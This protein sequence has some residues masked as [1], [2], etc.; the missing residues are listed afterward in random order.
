VSHAETP[1][2][3]ESAPGVVSVEELDALKAKVQELTAA[4]Q[5]IEGQLEQDKAAAAEAEKKA[6]V[7][8]T[9][10]GGLRIASADKRYEL[11]IGGSI[12]YDVA[13]FRQDD[14]LK[15]AV[16]D[17]Q[18]GTGFRFA[19]LRLQ[20]KLAE[21]VGFRA[22]YDFAGE[23]AADSPK[24]MDVYIDYLGIPWGGG[25]AFDVRAGHFREPF[26][27]EE[28]TGIANRTF[29]ERS[30]ANVFVPSRNAGV[31][32]SDALFGE[33]EKERLTLALGVFKETDDWPSSNDSDEDQ[34]YIVTGRVTGLPYYEED[35]RRLVHVGLSYS[36]RNPEGAPLR[37]GVRP[38]SRL[39]LFRYADTSSLPVGFRLRDARAETVDLIGGELAA[40]YGPFSVQ[41][42]YIR[43][44]VDTTFGGGLSVDGY[45]AQ[46]SYF[47]TGEHRPYRNAS[48]L[49]DRVTP[50]T[51]ASWKSGQERGWGAWEVA[52]RWS[53]VNLD[54]GWLRAGQH[55]AATLGLN[56]Y[57]NPN[58]RIMW[59]V[60]RN[61]VDHDLYEGDFDAFQ[62][63]FQVEF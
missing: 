29:T 2:A 45:Y 10:P 57:L 30:L 17:E 51:N 12:G 7:V 27:L 24:F 46:A 5:E 20:G 6:P 4:I 22:E 23:N 52:A 40:V 50:K 59:N 61:F 54:D 32:V 42:E 41:G 14:E 28:M 26:S 11:R 38:E 56:W 60:T 49:F 36:H 55:D 31:Q 33:A 25:R 9:G 13:W 1:T 39:A 3:T 19:R 47:L 62:T 53:S 15:Q 58:A 43:S 8:S 37:Y 48:G 63:R 16:G 18:D 44:E 35:G 21:N 34:G